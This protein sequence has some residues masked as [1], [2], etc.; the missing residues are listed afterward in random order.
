[1][2]LIV[3]QKLRRVLEL[4]DRYKWAPKHSFSSKLVRPWGPDKSPVYCFAITAGRLLPRNA[5]ARTLNLTG[6]DVDVADVLFGP[7]G[8][9][10]E[11][12]LVHRATTTSSSLFHGLDGPDL[13][14]NV[15]LDALRNFRVSVDAHRLQWTLL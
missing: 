4:A 2:R 5:P 7:D 14:I 8:D 6:G 13:T 15:V 10:S 9:N 1:M 12:S 11:L 3:I